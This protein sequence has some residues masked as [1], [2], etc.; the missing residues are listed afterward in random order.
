MTIVVYRHKYSSRLAIAMYHFVKGLIGSANFYWQA[1]ATHIITITSSPEILPCIRIIKG[2]HEN[3][4][5]TL[6]TIGSQ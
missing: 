2:G 5:R 3:K 6:P 1:I 4:D